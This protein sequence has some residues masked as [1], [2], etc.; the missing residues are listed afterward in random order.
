[1]SEKLLSEQQIN[2]RNLWDKISFV[3]IALFLA[4]STIVSVTLIFQKTYFSVKWVN[5]QSMYPTFN[6]DTVDRYGIKKGRSG[7]NA[8]NGDK[9]FDCV[10]WDGHEQTM[11]RLER[12]DVVIATQPTNTSK[13]LIKRVI[14]L[15][16]ETFYFSNEE[17]TKGNLY[18]MDSNGEFVYTPQPIAD[19]FLKEGDYSLFSEPT[20]LKE[21]EYVICGDNR[22][23]SYDCRS[24]GAIDR[25]YIQGIVVA[26][27][28]SADAT[29]D[30]LG[31]VVY[32]NL[33]IGWPRWI[34]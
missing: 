12:F 24:F 23:H 18:L 22:G 9:N 7:G 14:A 25:S 32:E 19:E 20:T 33:R 17:E 4:L 11:K 26:V 21:N 13:D 31:N 28:G 10:I 16:G 29:L 5:G 1:M 34:K 30:S 15:P 6:K 8:N 27:V 3:L 2:R